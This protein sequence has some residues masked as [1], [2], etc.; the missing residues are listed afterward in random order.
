MA[1]GVHCDVQQHLAARHARGRAVGEGEGDRLVDL[2]GLQRI[3]IVDVPVRRGAGAFGQRVKRRQLGR[4]RRGVAVRPRLEIVAEDL[5]DHLDVI[6]QAADQD[7][8]IRRHA[9]DGLGNDRMQAVGRPALLVNQG[10][11]G[12]GEHR[13]AFPLPVGCWPHIRE[14]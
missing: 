2:F 4:A 5:V 11:I 9:V 13:N 10:A 8:L 14:L 3:G 12:K 7:L 6:E 1:G